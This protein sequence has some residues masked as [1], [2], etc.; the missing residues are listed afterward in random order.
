[1]C[2]FPVYFTSCCGSSANVL[3]CGGGADNSF[4][5]FLCFSVLRSVLHCMLGALPCD[6]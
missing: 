6:G 1:M 5:A 2:S 3:S 4:V